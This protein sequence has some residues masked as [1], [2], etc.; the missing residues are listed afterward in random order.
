MTSQEHIRSY[1]DWLRLCSINLFEQHPAPLRS[2]S[3]PWQIVI[4]S[5]FY[6]HRFVI[7]KGWPHARVDNC[8]CYYFFP[9]K[10]R[11]REKSQQLGAKQL[12]VLSEYQNA[13]VPSAWCCWVN[14]LV[15]K[16]RQREEKARTRK[17][18]RGKNQEKEKR[19]A[20][21]GEWWKGHG[22]VERLSQRAEASLLAFVRVCWV[23]CLDIITVSPHPYL[24]PALLTYDRIQSRGRSTHDF[25]VILC[26][27]CD[28]V[29]VV[30]VPR[31]GTPPWPG[32][33]WA[34]L[35]N[36]AQ[37]G[38][39]CFHLCWDSLTLVC[40]ATFFLFWLPFF[41]SLSISWMR[42]WTSPP[43]PPTIFFFPFRLFGLFTS[44][45]FNLNHPSI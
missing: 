18:F 12:F 16:S 32:L 13:K 14:G 7:G 27:S 24:L 15:Q 17:S 37:N 22:V 6:P 38:Q 5:L 43:L 19:D 23:A 20:C 10:E 30:A 35:S 11:E 3:S 8:I 4:P 9:I 40:L 31:G 33:S 44:L 25:V 39:V 28:L 45:I 2:L 36:C 21:R 34:Q 26:K 1:A 29:L 41:F 42:S